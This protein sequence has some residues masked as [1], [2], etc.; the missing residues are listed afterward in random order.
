MSLFLRLIGFTI[1][2]NSIADSTIKPLS[3][4]ITLLITVWFYSLF[5]VLVVIRLIT[6]SPVLTMI[7]SIIVVMMSRKKK[8]LINQK[9][10]YTT[11]IISLS[12]VRSC[13]THEYDQLTGLQMSQMSYKKSS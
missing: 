9:L 3:V 8:M 2:K 7:L 1:K 5:V 10:E 4:S 11:F 13:W 12:Q 6:I